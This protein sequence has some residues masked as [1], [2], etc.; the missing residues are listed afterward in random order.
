MEFMTASSSKLGLWSVS[1]SRI[2]GPHTDTWRNDHTVCHNGISISH[3]CYQPTGFLFFHF[4][5][6]TCYFIDSFLWVSPV[7]ETGFS[8][9]HGDLKH[10]SPEDGFLLLICLSN[11][12]MFCFLIIAMIAC[13]LLYLIVALTC[14]FLNTRGNIFSG[15]YVLFAC[16]PWIWLLL[17]GLYSP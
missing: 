6:N 8:V 9:T 14:I 13:V 2:V 17:C 7:V 3:L 4:L 1:R 11:T 12:G 15:A 5:A 10:Y 16:F